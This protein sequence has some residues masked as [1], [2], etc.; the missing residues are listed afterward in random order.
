MHTPPRE[1]LAFLHAHG[2]EISPVGWQDL[3]TKV[4][5]TFPATMRGRVQD[6]LTAEEAQALEGGG[7]DLQEH[8][9]GARDPVAQAAAEF[10]AIVQGALT[11]R[12]VAALLGVTEARVRQRLEERSLYG[13]KWEGRWRVPTF[14]F[15]FEG[16]VLPG[17]EEILNALDPGVHPVELANWLTTPDPE[18]RAQGQD[19]SPAQWLTLGHAPQPVARAARDL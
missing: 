12:A 1:T 17:F 16:T 7:G 19:L 2:L 8:E 9:H 3:L 13:F 10:F 5:G 14:Q 6:E 18:L 4:V 15:T 11:T